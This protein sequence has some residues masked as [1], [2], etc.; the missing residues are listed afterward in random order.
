MDYDKT[1]TTLI[2]F[3]LD[4]TLIDVFDYHVS[5]LTKVIDRV[6]DIPNNLPK[7]KRY[8][9][10]QRETLRRVCEANGISDEAYELDSQRA[11]TLLTEAM[12]KDLPVDLTPKLLPGAIELLDTLVASQVIH[13]ALATGTLGPTA[14]IILQRSGLA[15]YFP[16][17]AYGHEVY[18]RADL[19]ELA[20]NRAL[21]FYQLDAETI[22]VV[23]IG[24]APA[25]IEAGR[26]IGAWTVSV[27]SSSFS[28]DQLGAFQPDVLLSSLEDIEGDIST[29][30]PNYI[31]RSGW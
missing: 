22:H 8:G 25:D 28:E 15:G 21:A 24:D 20:R 5:S 13:L 3:D 1:D 27:A 29:L 11:Q 14:E 30:L 10:P 16:V 9:I 31:I 6:W 19:I 12:A 7:S 26:S 23:T 17:G 4:G 18:T 2:I